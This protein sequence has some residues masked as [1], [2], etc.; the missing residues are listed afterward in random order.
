MRT[1]AAAGLPSP[2]SKSTLDRLGGRRAERRHRARHRLRHAADAVGVGAG[3]D[4]HVRHALLEARGVRGQHEHGTR[5]A[6]AVD[7]HGDRNQDGPGDP[8]TARRQEHDTAGALVGSAVNCLLE[9]V[10]VVGPAVAPGVHDDRTRVVRHGL[11]GGNGCLGRAGAAGYGGGAVGGED[12]SKRQQAKLVRSD[13]QRG[14]LDFFV[15][16]DA[17]IDLAGDMETFAKN[18]PVLPLTG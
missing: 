8:V 6:D 9:G 17:P 10:A 12:G 4:H 1:P 11:V 13:L 15:C 5:L 2:T 7:A 3:E 14:L 18:V 16:R